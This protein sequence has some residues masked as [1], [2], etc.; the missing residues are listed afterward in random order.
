MSINV[1]VVACIVRLTRRER[2]AVLDSRIVSVKAEVPAEKALIGSRLLVNYSGVLLPNMVLRT[3]I[4]FRASIPLADANK[5]LDVVAEHGSAEIQISP[6]IIRP[7]AE[8]CARVPLSLLRELRGQEV[9]TEMSRRALVKM[10]SEE[11]TT[12]KT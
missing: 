11:R 7:M 3:G 12:G 10:W 4:L 8:P 6:D 5:A 2:A 9:G 1:D